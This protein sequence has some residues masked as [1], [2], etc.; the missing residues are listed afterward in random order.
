MWHVSSRS[1]VAT[2]RTAIHLLLTY[3]LTV[4]SCECPDCAGVVRR[5]PGSDSQLFGGASYRVRHLAVRS[6]QE[7]LLQLRPLQHARRPPLDDR[8]RTAQ[9]GTLFC[10]AS[11][12]TI[13]YDTRCY[14]NV[15]SKADIS[16]LNL[17]HG[18]QSMLSVAW[19]NNNNNNL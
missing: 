5:S 2:L 11:Y 19:I 7:V 12:D 18:V 4:A 10:A 9:R 16:Q 1:G 8:I 17:P 13:R 3:L 14:F 15:R 6:R